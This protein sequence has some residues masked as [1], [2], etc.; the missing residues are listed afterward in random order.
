MRP[1][2][3]STNIKKSSLEQK[4]AESK[5]ER[6]HREPSSLYNKTS[7]ARSMTSMTRMQLLGSKRQACCCLWRIKWVPIA[8]TSQC[9]LPGRDS[10]SVRVWSP[11]QFIN[12]RDQERHAS[13]ATQRNKQA[14]TMLN[15]IALCRLRQSIA[16]LAMISLSRTE[17]IRSNISMR[18][19]SSK[20]SPSYKQKIWESA[21]PRS[22]LRVTGHECASEDFGV[23]QDREV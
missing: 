19:Q 21:W 12:G 5:F 1:H 15:S 16:N 7:D 8:H 14:Q 3:L 18:S 23:K 10:S 6:Y 2:Y 17:G 13:R 9:D 20:K 4:K 22:S 11:A